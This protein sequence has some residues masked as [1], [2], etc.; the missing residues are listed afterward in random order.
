ML[1]V[2]ASYP[3]VKRAGIH[4]YKAI[5]WRRWLFKMLLGL[6]MLG[7][8]DELL[9]AKYNSPVPIYPHFPFE[10]FSTKIRQDIGIEDLQIVVSFPSMLKRG[11]FYANL[12][13]S[14]AEQ[15]GFVKVSVDALNNVSFT[16]EAETIR[17]LLTRSLHS[18]EFP[19][20]LC[21]GNINSYRYII[22]EP[23][24]ANARPLKSKWDGIPKLC[25]D[26]LITG[27]CRVQKIEELSW[28]SSFQKRTS[29][30]KP[31]ADEI[32]SWTDREA[33][34]C[35][36]HGDFTGS[37][38]C[39]DNGLIWVFDWEDSAPDAPIMTDEVR[40]FLEA[41]T[42]LLVNNPQKAAKLLARRF[43][44]V[45]DDEA[46]KNLALSLAFLCSRANGSGIIMGKHW[47]QIK[48]GGIHN[49]E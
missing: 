31:L 22:W 47:Y 49:A 33:T 2:P 13:S 9:G 42:R 5:S 27:S 41:R 25:R 46:N 18:F 36:A 23:L 48:W 7:R 35:F 28:W 24:P 20:I 19:K 14:N 30:I 12:L 37:N 16:R 26:E 1:S 4:L 8:V 38:M 40:F 11:R 15:L 45:V 43:L 32:N 39:N 34:V 29:D 21:E 6:C 3:K 17:T 44:A 10:T